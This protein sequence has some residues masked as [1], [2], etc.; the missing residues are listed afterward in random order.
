MRNERAGKYVLP[1]LEFIAARGAA[2]TSEIASEFKVWS[3]SVPII[4]QPSVTAGFVKLQLV[5]LPGTSP[6]VMIRQYFDANLDEYEALAEKKASALVS[7]I[8]AYASD[9]ESGIE[10]DT[11]EFVFYSRPRIISFRPLDISRLKTKVIR[12]GMWDYKNIPSLFM[13]AEK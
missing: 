10:P 8:K 12:E 11:T 4:L 7:T 6:R 5:P 9:F 3:T 1:M 13:K 2:I